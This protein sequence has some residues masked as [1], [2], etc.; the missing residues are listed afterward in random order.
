VPRNPDSPAFDWHERKFY[1]NLSYADRT[2]WAWEWLRRNEGYAAMADTAPLPITEILRP[3]PPIVVL[4]MPEGEGGMSDWG[5][6]FC[7]TT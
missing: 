6:H 3:E 5:L 1:Q 4:T 7:G 2:G